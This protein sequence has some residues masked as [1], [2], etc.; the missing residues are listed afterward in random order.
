MQVH[1]PEPLDDLEQESR[2]VAFA[3]GVVEV[4]ALQHFTHVRAEPGDVVPQI[5]REMRRVGQELV[6][7]VA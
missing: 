6:E 3:D 2:F 1:L 4:E 7:V 5:G